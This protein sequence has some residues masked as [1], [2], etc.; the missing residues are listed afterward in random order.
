MLALTTP[1]ISVAPKPRMVI[2]YTCPVDRTYTK[3]L[4]MTTPGPKRV[5]HISRTPNISSVRGE[6]VGREE[7]YI[8]EVLP[9]VPTTDCR[10]V[11]YKPIPT[12]PTEAEKDEYRHKLKA[13]QSYEIAGQWLNIEISQIPKIVSNV[14]QISQAASQ[15]TSKEVLSF[16]SYPM[17]SCTPNVDMYQRCL[18]AYE[19]NQECFLEMLRTTGGVGGENSTIITQIQELETWF[20]YLLEPP[21]AYLAD[22]QD[23]Y[24]RQVF[25]RTNMKSA[26]CHRDLYQFL[27]TPNSQL[28]QYILNNYQTPSSSRRR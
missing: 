13:D 16:S 9:Y 11:R 19:N 26:Y 18:E 23:W 20:L 4:M 28:Q 15:C 7:G 21:P 6:G 25:T 24:R 2:S 5:K 10:V 1:K 8:T 27:G 22:L 14:R 3:A 17:T 12:I